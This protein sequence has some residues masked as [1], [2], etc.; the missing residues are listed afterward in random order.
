V[1]NAL[2]YPIDPVVIN[3]L[4]TIDAVCSCPTIPGNVNYNFNFFQQNAIPH[5]LPNVLGYSSNAIIQNYDFS[6][7]GT[8]GHGN[9]VNTVAD[10]VVQTVTTN[11][12]TIPFKNYYPIYGAQ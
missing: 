11:D 10:A 1:A 12:P 6:V 2:N 4:I 9:I 5:G 8:I 7:S 3:F